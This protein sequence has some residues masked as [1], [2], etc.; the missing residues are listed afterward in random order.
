MWEVIFWVLFILG[1][2]GVFFILEYLWEAYISW[3]FEQ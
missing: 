3:P 2:F 1:L